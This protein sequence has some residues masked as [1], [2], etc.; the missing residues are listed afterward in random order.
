MTE[1]SDIVLR[2]YES[3]DLDAIVELDAECFEPPFRFSQGRHAKV[4]R[5]GECVGG[6]G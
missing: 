3:R 1:R 2:S 5:G 6:G 4:R